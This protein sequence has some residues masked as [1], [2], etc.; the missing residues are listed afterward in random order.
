[1]DYAIARRRM[2]EQHI[3]G[4]GIRDPQ[5]LQVMQQIPRHLFVEPALQNQAYSD[6]ALPIGEKQTISQPYMVAVMTEAALLQPDD[7]VLEIGTGCGYQTAVLA[8]LAGQVYSIER[9]A[10]LAR[11]ARKILD[12]LGC[13]NLVVQ[14][15]DGTLGW[16]DQAPFDAIVV[17]AGAPE[18]PQAYLEQLAVGGRLVIP[19]GPQDAQILKRIIRL[20]PDQFDEEALLSCRFVPLVGQAGW[21]PSC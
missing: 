1:M 17:T 18:V 11:R 6:Y 14:V 16:P 19:V 21:S 15:G 12:S 8:A 10:G 13:R 20:G 9:L 4:R 7:R 2:V 5:L 3:A